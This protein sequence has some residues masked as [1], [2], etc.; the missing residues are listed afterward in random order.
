L[1]I[2]DVDRALAVVR[3][4][5]TPARLAVPNVSAVASFNNTDPACG[6]R[7]QVR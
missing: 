3:S 1:R 6:N 4:Y 2:G 7:Q 5:S